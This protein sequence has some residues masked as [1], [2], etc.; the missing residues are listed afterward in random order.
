MIVNVAGVPRVAPPLGLLR[1]SPNA[2]LPP[3][4]MFRIGTAI[5]LL[6]SPGLKVRT[7]ET[8]V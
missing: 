6:V 5:V 8:G 1:T 3:A 4:V 2:R 7:P